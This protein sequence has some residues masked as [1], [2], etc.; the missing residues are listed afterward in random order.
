M[1]T[2]K[3]ELII[4]SYNQKIQ[5]YNYLKIQIHFYFSFFKISNI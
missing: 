2:F 1:L 4:L 3:A 5:K